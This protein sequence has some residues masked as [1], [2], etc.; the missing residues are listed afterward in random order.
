MRR[1]GKTVARA[2]AAYRS[3]APYGTP[4]R[5][6]LLKGALATLVLVAARLS[7]PWP[8]R[9]LLEIVFKNNTRAHA[10][11]RFVPHRGDPAL[12]LIGAF[13]V[14]IL[15]WGVAESRQRLA[16]TR[17]AVGLSQGIRDALLAALP[18]RSRRGSS[19]D[20]IST[21]TGDLSRV[22]TGVKSIL[23]GVSRN[24]VFFLGV[25]VIVTLIDGMVGLVF[26]CGGVATV[27]AGAFGA[28]RS[29]VLM[30]RS[31]KREGALADDLHRYLAGDPSCAPRP[32]LR[33]QRPDSKM[34]RVEGITTFVVHAILA[35]STCAIL[36]LTI[37]H[38]RSGRL[39]PGAV[40][41]ILAYIL[42]MHNKTVGL[43]RSVV[44]AGRVLPSAERIASALR[45]EPPCE[46]ATTSVEPHNPRQH[47]VIT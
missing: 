5:R 6:Q 41:T 24:G 46:T 40:F 25:T 43:G 28:S 23:I 33:D 15:V 2:R 47:E 18:G 17:Y 34:T 39:T 19:G 7:F 8:L 35:A 22:K 38:A 32:S 9:G 1:V 12:W 13:V 27:I 42:L 26:L 36:L 11:V 4:H 37:Q 29:A 31:R 30:R 44:R 20:V 21:L 3:L 10:V 16:F 14:V 45:P